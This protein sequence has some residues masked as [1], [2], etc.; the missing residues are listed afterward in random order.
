ME[1]HIDPPPNAAILDKIRDKKP[2]P[3]MKYLVFNHALYCYGGGR[4]LIGGEWMMPLN[5]NMSGSGVRGH[6]S[7]GTEDR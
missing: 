1:L 2:V 5:E 4:S 6:P 7:S 3:R